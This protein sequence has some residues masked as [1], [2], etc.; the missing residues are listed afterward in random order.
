MTSMSSVVESAILPRSTLNVLTLN[1]LALLVM[2]NAD[3][4]CDCPASST[5]VVESPTLST[6]RRARLV[7]P[8]A[9][10]DWSRAPPTGF[11]TITAAGRAARRPCSPDV[12]PA[13]VTPW[14]DLDRGSDVADIFLSSVHAVFGASLSVELNDWL[15]VRY[16]WPYLQW[17]RTNEAAIR[18]TSK[19]PIATWGAH[20]HGL[21]DRKEAPPITACVDAVLMTSM[22]ADA[23]VLPSKTNWCRVIV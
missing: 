13:T 21:P 12:V 5:V 1:V 23:D 4:T 6:E 14:P 3:L 7:V 10:D 20:S 16:L 17:N 22:T 18:R 8:G 15:P 2:Y 11:K 19:A 9:A